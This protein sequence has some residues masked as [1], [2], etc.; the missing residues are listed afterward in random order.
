[1]GKFQIINVNRILSA[2][3][4]IA[5]EYPVKINEAQQLNKLQ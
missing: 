3:C 4:L 1:M 5:V 2:D